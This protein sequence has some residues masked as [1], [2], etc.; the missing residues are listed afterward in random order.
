MAQLACLADILHRYW[1]TSYRVIRHCQ[2][3][4]WHIAWVVLEELL[5][6]DEVH[7]ALEWEFELGV[8]RLFDSYINGVCLACLDMPL[9]RIEMRI[10][11]D[12]LSLFH[13]VREE[14]ILC[15]TTLVC[16]DNILKTSDTSDSVFQLEERFTTRITL[17]AEHQCSPLAVG[18]SSCTRVGQQVDIHLLAAEHKDVVLGFTEPLF[19]LCAGGFADGLYHLNLP[20][21]CKR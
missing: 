2:H 7:I 9:G 10:A 21:F 19:A 4:K 16:W 17:I 13:E 18:H 6:V 3:H 8:L 12:H 5:E 14:H 20:R 1:L 11:R 15:R